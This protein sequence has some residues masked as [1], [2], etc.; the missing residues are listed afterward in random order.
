MKCPYRKETKF[1]YVYETN[2]N[3]FWPVEKTQEEF[4]DCIGFECARAKKV[5]DDTILCGELSFANNVHGGFGKVNYSGVR[6]ADEE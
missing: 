6:F 3:G 5:D 2:D 4:L 1:F